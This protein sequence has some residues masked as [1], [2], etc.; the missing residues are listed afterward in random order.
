VKTK[1]E[2]SEGFL[3]FRLSDAS[4]K[5]T[6]KYYDTFSFSPE[7]GKFAVLFRDITKQK[8]EADELKK[9]RNHLEELVKERTQNLEDK[10]IELERFHKLFID[11]EFR[12]KELRDEI[13]KLE[14]AKLKATHRR[15]IDDK[16]D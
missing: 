9:Y 11:R 7:K 4:D 1:I 14:K 8:K 16:I 10:N 12:I 13:K 5:N 2:D 3:K 6:K 15:A